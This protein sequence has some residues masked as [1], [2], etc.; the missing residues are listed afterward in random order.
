MTPTQLIEDLKSLQNNILSMQKQPIMGW[1]CAYIPE[2]IPMAFGFIPFRVRGA[3]IPTGKA[4]GLMPG[5]LCPHILSCLEV[6]FNNGYNFL[7]GII[8]ANTSDAMR[9]LF[10]VW[11]RYI[12]T[13]F[14]HMLDV[15]KEINEKSKQYFVQL[16]MWLIESMEKYYALK[17]SHESLRDAILTCNETRRLLDK[18][19]DMKRNNCSSLTNSFLAEITNLSVSL[20]KSE[21]NNYLRKFID[22]YCNNVPEKNNLPKILI[23]GS[24]YDQSD[25]E[26]IVENSG[27]KI[28]YEDICTRGRYYEDTVGLQED[29]IISLAERYL[30]R[31]PCARMI[32]SERRFNY[33]QSL[34][35]KYN[36]DAVIYYALKFDDA[37]LFEFPLLRRW[38]LDTG[39]PVLF[40]EGDRRLGYLGQV[41]TRIQA[42]LESL[43]PIG[44][45]L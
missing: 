12:N 6:A 31:A 25:L 2:E 28:V 23:T 3:P 35:K 19:Y 41:K 1:T 5:N 36:V 20:P 9:R 30:T 11:Q 39:I 13:P 27:G 33:L 43:V 26:D 4:N 16:L 38:L 8:I 44:R 40:I 42:F 7:N 10:D 32:D 34:I 24:F 37:Y 45:D 21:F 18:L 17:I 29:L 14:I 22:T 15:P